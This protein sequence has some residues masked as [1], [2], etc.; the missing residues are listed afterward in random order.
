MYNQTIIR[1]RYTELVTDQQQNQQPN[2]SS[3]VDSVQYEH[4]AVVPTVST[5]SHN[6]YDPRDQVV[7]GYRVFSRRGTDLDIR[8]TD[9]I[10]WANKTWEVSADPER[11]PHPV[12]GRGAVHHVEIDIQ[13]VRG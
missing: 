6:S 4:C 11:W 1:D 9:R 13:A 2:W 5:E 10:R 12:R 3:G 7:T 8:V